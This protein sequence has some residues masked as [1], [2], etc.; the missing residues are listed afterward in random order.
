MA[1]TRA[2]ADR[3]APSSDGGTKRSSV[4]KRLPRCWSRVT[5]GTSRSSPGVRRAAGLPY[6][7]MVRSVGCE[8]ADFVG[9]ELDLVRARDRQRRGEGGLAGVRCTG[10]HD[11]AGWS[12]HGGGVQRNRRG[13]PHG[14]GDSLVDLHQHVGHHRSLGERVVDRATVELDAEPRP[15]VIGDV[16]ERVRCRFGGRLRGR[17]TRLVVEAH[18]DE[19]VVEGGDD[20]GVGR[21]DVEPDAVCLESA[22]TRH[23]RANS[24]IRCRATDRSDVASTRPSR[25]SR[26][27]VENHASDGWRTANRLRSAA[28]PLELDRHL[29][30]VVGF[31]MVGSRVEG[32][33]AG[34]CCGLPGR[35]RRIGWV[36]SGRMPS[37]D[38]RARA[39]R[40]RSIRRS[41]RSTSGVP[42]CRPVRGRGRPTVPVVGRR[43]GRCGRCLRRCASPTT[44]ACRPGGRVRRRARRQGHAVRRRRVVTVPS[45]LARGE[46]GGRA[47]GGGPRRPR[48]AAGRVRAV[49]RRPR[50]HRGDHRRSRTRATPAG[51]NRGVGIGAQ[52]DELRADAQR[53]GARSNGAVERR[54][55]KDPAARSGSACRRRR[56][57]P[58]T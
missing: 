44:P 37:R 39:V 51:A 40:G 49:R 4:S 27:T 2:G 53:H 3:D 20:V 8:R 48:R 47:A 1:T 29:M 25:M 35:H 24:T 5:F 18:V 57:S 31:V 50:A 14:C 12:G 16:P 34:E 19:E 11:G 17:L 23:R 52:A 45:V 32:D 33:D 36:Q 13:R 6:G 30:V 26:S 7:A 41:R 10:E 54:C 58:R 21:R 46:A 22:G 42:R 28:A 43:P 38:D 55:L 15:D 9:E 56:A